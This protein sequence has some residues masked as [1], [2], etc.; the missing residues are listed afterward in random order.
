MPPPAK[1]P[2][3]LTGQLLLLLAGLAALGSLVTNI[4]LP[5]FPALAADL[6]TSVQGLSVKLANFFVA[7]AVGQLFV[8]PLSD[9]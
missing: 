5:A 1:A 4:I 9:H 3:R 7:F 2:T 8:G 6:T